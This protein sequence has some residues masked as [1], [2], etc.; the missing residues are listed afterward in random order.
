MT[1]YSYSLLHVGL[2]LGLIFEPEDG[3]D[4][5]L[6]NVVEFYRDYTAMYPR[7]WNCSLTLL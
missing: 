2:L 3:G 1:A 4:T 7:R 6:R 5:I